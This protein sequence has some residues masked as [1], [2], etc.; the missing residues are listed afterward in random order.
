MG[1]Q[2]IS[3]NDKYNASSGDG[4]ALE[5]CQIRGV[6][7]QGT[8]PFEETIATSLVDK[9]TFLMLPGLVV[10]I[11]QIGFLAF[12]NQWPFLLVPFHPCDS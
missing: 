4:Y 12:G 6:F 8:F 11:G 2:L 1:G 7:L 5:W 3:R 10:L 9:Y